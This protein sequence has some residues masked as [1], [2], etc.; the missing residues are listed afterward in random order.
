LHIKK[1]LFLSQRKY[2]LDQL[3]ETDKL[4]AKPASTIMKPNKKLY[5]DDDEPL[6]DIRQY[7][8]LIGKLIYMCDPFSS[9]PHRC[10]RWDAEEGHGD[11]S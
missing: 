2:I 10:G 3:K 8:R 11:P 6:K 7:Q 4:C 1:Y 5:L 9:A